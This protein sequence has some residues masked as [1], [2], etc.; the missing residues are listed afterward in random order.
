MPGSDLER[1]APREW[2]RPL[3]ELTPDT[4]YGFH[5][6]DW[7]RE[8][9]RIELDPWQRWLLI[10]A[11][12]LLPSGLPR[13]RTVL[14]LVARQNGKT[15]ALVVLAAYW[16]F[17]ECVALVLGTSTNLEMAK[18]AWLRMVKAVR[19]AP[20][21]AGAYP[22]KWTRTANGGVDCWTVDDC[23]YT[24]APSTV[25]GGRS[26]TIHRLITDELREHRSYD[27]WNASTGA[28]VAVPDAQTWALSNAGGPHSVV[29]ND[30][31][32]EGRAGETDDLGYFG[33]TAPPGSDPLDEDALRL[34]NPSPRVSI[35]ALKAKARAA[36]LAGGE[37]LTG[38]Q[39]EHM[40]ITVPTLNPAIDPGAWERC[41]DDGT[42]D[43]VR[44][45]TAMCLDVAPDGQ[46]AT[47]AAAAMLEDG[48]T[49]V[50]LVA[51]WSGVGAVD[52]LRRTL[53]ALVRRTRPAVLGWFPTG[54][55]AELTADMAARWPAS[56]T[57][58][59]I[60][61]DMPA[62]C[63]ALAGLAGV[64]RI[65]HSGDPL[66]DAQTAAAERL[67]RGDAWVFARPGDGHVDA[68][69]AVAGAVQLARTLPPPV[70]EPRLVV[71]TDG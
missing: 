6:I 59:P 36:V 45:R 28:T 56:L 44:R 19:A 30:L 67:P 8:F 38:F 15:L 54:P 16:L 43:A 12:E 27:L 23:H 66:L 41:R 60:R 47:L 3:R 14:V 71:V 63:M 9:L 11:G 7:A 2:T 64:Q 65:A 57:V 5:V 34:A 46:H 49:R 31:M 39:T 58:E 48:R 10:H 24:I 4:S 29:L 18:V 68:V 52:R 53:P 50:E 33:W 25:Q 17:V 1:A 35:V 21:L 42:L 51:A 61:G 37:R 70:G 40:C 62:A 13:F 32:A 55:A 69:Y 22:R 26:L 20:L